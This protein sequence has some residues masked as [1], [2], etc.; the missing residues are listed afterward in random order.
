MRSGEIAAFT[1]LCQCLIIRRPRRLIDHNRVHWPTSC[2]QLQTQS[3]ERAKHCQRNIFILRIK[4]LHPKIV[5]PRQSCL[6][7][8]W[9][10]KVVLQCGR[11]GTS[12]SADSISCETG[13]AHP[14]R[15]S[16][17]AAALCALRSSSAVFAARQR[18]D[19]HIVSLMPVFNRRDAQSPIQD[20]MLGCT[21]I[22]RDFTEIVVKTKRK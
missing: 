5:R 17:R 15:C 20:Y 8:H 18:Q 6:V 16:W 19:V 10:L 2:L 21:K 14:G 11:L 1:N 12:C 4:R 9:T 7:H 3:L 22:L 13:S